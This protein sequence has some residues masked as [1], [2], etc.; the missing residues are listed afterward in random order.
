[1]DKSAI[2]FFEK[3][4][5]VFRG[6]HGEIQG[7]IARVYYY[8]GNCYIYPDPQRAIGFISNSIEIRKQL[9]GEQNRKVA[10]GYFLL[11]YTYQMIGKNELS[12]QNYQQSLSIYRELPKEYSMF[13][14]NLLTSIGSILSNWGNDEK[15]I[16]YFQLALRL[17][18]RSLNLK[19]ILNRATAYSNISDGYIAM[20]DY[21]KALS[22]NQK[23]LAIRLQFL[24]SDHPKV[25]SSYYRIGWTFSEIGKQALALD[26]MQRALSINLKVFGKTSRNVAIDYKGL[27]NV[28]LRM[29]DN[30]TALDYYKKAHPIWKNEEFIGRSFHNIGLC[31]SKIGRQDKA[32][33]N[34]Q[35]ALSFQLMGHETKNS[36]LARTYCN[37]AKVYHKMG[38]YL[39][40]LDYYQKVIGI[41]VSSL[42]GTDLYTLPSLTGA[43]YKM[44]LIWCLSGKAETLLQLAAKDPTNKQALPAAL[45][46]CLLASD[47]MDT[48]RTEFTKAGKTQLFTEYHTIYENGIYAAHQRFQQTN[49]SS[50]L[51]DAFR[52]FEKSKSLNLLETLQDGKAR[53]FAA[54]PDSLLKKERSILTRL[55]YYEKKLVEEEAQPTPDSSRI[56]EVQDKIFSYKQQRDSLKSYFQDHFPR[57]HTLRYDLKVATPQEVQASL[58]DSTT[59]FVEYY[60][61]DSALYIFHIT[62]SSYSLRALPRNPALDTTLQTFLGYVSQPDLPDAD[63]TQYP[64]LAHDLYQHLLGPE[65]GAGSSPNPEASSVPHLILVPDGPL[66][67]LPFEAL[68]TE[69]HA[70]E[71]HYSFKSLPYL[72]RRYSS[73]Y[74]WSA[75]VRQ[76]DL[77]TSAP[78]PAGNLNRRSSYGEPYAFVAFAP[79]YQTSAADSVNTHEGEQGFTLIPSALREGDSLRETLSPL[80]YAK[81]EAE[82]ASQTMGGI[83]FADLNASE[84]T[85]REVAP[86]A[87]IL[88]FAGH[89]LMDAEHPEYSRLKFMESVPDSAIAEEE[90]DHYDGDLLVS[91]LFNLTLHAELAVLS[92]CQTGAGTAQSGEGILSLGRAFRYAGCRNVLMTHWPVEDQATQA[93][94]QSFYQYLDQGSSIAEALRQARLDYLEASGSLKAHP[95]FWGAWTLMGE[96]VPLASATASESIRLW[97]MLLLSILLFGIAGVGTYTAVVKK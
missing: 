92:A 86:T 13:E 69:A 38:S 91:E 12:M 83:T 72:F 31:H 80:P 59:A 73:S 52:F 4:L 41:C 6:L 55:S 17:Q 11:G 67:K 24:D 64:T 62:P 21:P 16:E 37:I 54:I 60:Y 33:D 95:F 68:L 7:S 71:G 26:Y 61:G 84:K 23:A 35:M 34:L 2:L 90:Q 76:Q 8:L 18:P 65:L 27:G 50:Y 74:A 56:P 85:F 15:A 28:Y 36:K 96:N 48:L 1:M 53:Q 45:H 93:I 47:L 29:G 89:T 87:R 39:Q 30:L 57:Y 32:I 63:A 9:F 3:A 51:E 75:T 19:I 78:G 10:E 14:F 77:H 43:T 82:A 40:A 44:Y 22:Y 25:A 49:D 70:P 66:A 97:G 94:V 5:A 81:K 88:H 20:G 42:P 46:T 79:P 58:P